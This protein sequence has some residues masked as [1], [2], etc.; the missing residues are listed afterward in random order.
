MGMPG[1]K[2]ALGL[3]DTDLDLEVPDHFEVNALTSDFELGMTMTVASCKE[4]NRISADADVDEV[5]D[6]IDDMAGDYDA[7]MEALRDGITQYTDGVTKVSEGS[8]DLADGAAKLGQGTESLKDGAVKAAEGTK[9]LETG[10]QKM[11]TG[12]DTL[13]TVG[14]TQLVIGAQMLSQ[15]VTALNTEVQ[16]LSLDGLTVEDRELSPEEQAAIS[17]QISERGAAI[18]AA[19]GAGISSDV[20]GA[21][22]M[23]GLNTD[24]E[25]IQQDAASKGQAAGGAAGQNYAVTA[26]ETAVQRVAGM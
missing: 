5:A 24:A 13:R 23:A 4:M 3:K 19:N 8:K 9:A 1:L 15:G 21:K 16:K 2:D 18:A 14:N 26:Q 17:Q 10:L 11:S 20:I 6:Y 12:A 25:A 7:G 22:L